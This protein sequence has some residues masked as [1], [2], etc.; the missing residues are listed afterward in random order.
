MILNGYK[1]NGSVT[2]QGLIYQ[3]KKELKWKFECAKDTLREE[4]AR[5][6]NTVSCNML[7]MYLMIVISILFIHDM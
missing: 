6:P 7:Y 1:F 2:N 3:R 4:V 5:R